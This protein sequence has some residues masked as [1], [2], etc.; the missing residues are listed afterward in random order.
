MV[1][2]SMLCNPSIHWLM[3]H[4]LARMTT[5][6]PGELP[7]VYLTSCSCVTAAN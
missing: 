7:C 3:D 6:E 5:A 1:N 2:E 4:P